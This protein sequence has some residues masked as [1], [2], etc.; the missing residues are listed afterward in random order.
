MGKRSLTTYRHR[1][2]D[3]IKI[4]TQEIEYGGE[5]LGTGLI[6]LRTDQCSYVANVVLDFQGTWNMCIVLHLEARVSEM[7]LVS[8]YY[9]TRQP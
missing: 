6:S 2:E 4:Y 1:W 5:W 7:I 9:N 3:N 8:F